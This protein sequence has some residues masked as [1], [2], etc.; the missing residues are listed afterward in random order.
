[1][2]QGSDKFVVIT[3]H[4]LVEK[5]ENH[6]GK[7]HVTPVPMYKKE[8]VEMSE[9]RNGEVTGHHSLQRQWGEKATLSNRTC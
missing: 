3:Y 2:E 8:L 9:L 1:L 4:I 6:V 7:S 5:I